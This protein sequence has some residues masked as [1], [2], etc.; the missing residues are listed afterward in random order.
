MRY[1]GAESGFRASPPGIDIDDD[2]SSQSAIARGDRSGRRR[3]ARCRKQVVVPTTHGVASLTCVN[4][5]EPI[6]N[7]DF[8][9]TRLF[10][11]PW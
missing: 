2:D 4:G 7:R 3:L 5:I 11:G 6:L 1:A 8:F 10:C 9:A